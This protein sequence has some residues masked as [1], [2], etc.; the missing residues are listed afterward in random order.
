ME[1]LRAAFHSEREVQKLVL[2]LIAPQTAPG[3][4]L[5]AFQPDLEGLRLLHTHYQQ[6]ERTAEVQEITAHIAVVSSDEAQ[7]HRGLE[8]ARLWNEASRMHNELGD[9]PAALFAARESVHAAPLDF[10]MREHFAYTL[11]ATR[12]YTEAGKQWQWCLS[13]KPSSEQI[14]QQIATAKQLSLNEGRPQ[15]EQ[16]SRSLPYQ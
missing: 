13:R 10:D 8:A 5:V 1:L 4:F 14:R 16:A 12:H 11:M 7:R 9:Y 15:V 2:E 3:E 6:T